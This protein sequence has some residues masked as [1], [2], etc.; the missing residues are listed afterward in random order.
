MKRKQTQLEE[1]LLSIGYLL[2]YKD[3]KGKYS[4]I[5]HHYFYEKNV[6]FNGTSVVAQ[7]ILDYKRSYIVNVKIN[8]PIYG[9]ITESDAYDLLKIFDIVN[10]EIKSTYKPKD[11]LE[12]EPESPNEVIDIV[13]TFESDK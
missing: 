11:R 6:L 5:T 2:K 8:T 4:H 13:Q 7:V 12:L 1:K 9:F 3:Y 10:N